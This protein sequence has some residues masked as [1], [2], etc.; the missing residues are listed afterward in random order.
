MPRFTITDR[1]GRTG[2]IDY[3]LPVPAPVADWS[4]SN[5]PWKAVS[6]SEIDALIP[7]GHTVVP[8]SSTGADFYAKLN[9][10]LAAQSGRVSVRLPAGNYDFT[11]FRLIGSSGDPTYSFGHWSPKLAGFIGNPE[12]VF[13]RMAPNSMSQAQLDKMATMTLASFSQ[14]QM[15]VIRIDSEFNAV[16]APVVMLGITFESGPQQALTAKASDIP[17]DVYIPQPA[18]HGGLVIYSGSNRRHPDSIIAYCRF[19]GFGKAMMS[20]PPFEL[21]NVSSQRNQ[22]KWYRNEFDGRMSPTYDVNRPRKCG[23]FMVNGGIEQVMTDCWLHHSNVSRYAAN[24]EAV[25]S[26]TALSNHYRIER[27]KIEQITNNQNK[28]PPLN[29]GN[30]LG[31]YT[32]ASCIGFESSN[33][34]IEIID[35]IVSVDNDLIAGQVPCHIQF[36]NTGAARSGGRLYVKGGEF[37]HTKFPQLDGFLTVRIQQSSNWWTDGF[38]TTMDVRLADNTRLTPYVVTGTWPPTAQALATAGVTKQTH[39]LIRST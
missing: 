13:V 11:Q 37:R 26:A 5:P 28:Q 33:A 27:T 32:N 16:P 9:N 21:A 15:G 19:R 10:T 7:A 4:D 39:Y 18:P 22:V 2:F 14:L 12:E 30:S 35:S 29:G 38:N 1:K 17:A 34:L 8:L 6:Q 20:Q 31:G 24:D 23:V 25:A 3:D 36:T